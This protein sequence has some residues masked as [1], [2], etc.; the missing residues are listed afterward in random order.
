MLYELGELVKLDN[1]LNQL[2]KKVEGIV[3]NLEDTGSLV[4]EHISDKVPKPFNSLLMIPVI[5]SRGIKFTLFCGNLISK[6]HISSDVL[7]LLS[8]AT[9]QMV[10]AIE[11]LEHEKLILLNNIDLE[12]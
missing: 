3:T 11:K 9:K 6:K 4:Y 5:S 8:I 10:T 7:Q 1:S 2:H 12:K